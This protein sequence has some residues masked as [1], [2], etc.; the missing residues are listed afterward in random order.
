VGL[1]PVVS[2]GADRRNVEPVRRFEIRSVV[3][4]ADERVDRNIDSALDVAVATQGEIGEPAFL[5]GGH[6]KLH[7]RTRRRHRQIE[8][9]LELDLLR[10]RQSE[11]T[12][13]V[14]KWFLS[15]NDRAGSHGSDLANELNVFNRLCEE[16]QA[17]AILFEETQTRTIDLAVDE[18]TD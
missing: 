16:L 13:N 9:V 6:A 14:R 7:R 5:T 15:K 4:T 18:Q 2:F 17:A 11:S 1:L 3:E 8:R 10:L 12:S